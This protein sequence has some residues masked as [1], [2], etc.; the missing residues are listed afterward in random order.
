MSQNLK[1]YSFY[2]QFGKYPKCLGY[3]Y[4]KDKK[5]AFETLKLINGY[6]EGLKLGKKIKGYL[7]K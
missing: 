1:C 5:D 6:R 7:S 4:G 3:A 2:S